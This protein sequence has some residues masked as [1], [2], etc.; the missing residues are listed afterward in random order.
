MHTYNDGTGDCLNEFRKP[1]G[2][3]IWMAKVN[4]IISAK[5]GLS[6]DDL[7][8]VCYADWY[9]DEVSPTSAARRAIR[10]AQE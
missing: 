5:Y 8:D 3:D 10:Y 1:S 2:F 4:A 7:P 6:S 9:E